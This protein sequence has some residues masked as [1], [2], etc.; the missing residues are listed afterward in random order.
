MNRN[1]DRNGKRGGLSL[2]A[3]PLSYNSLLNK[4]LY[5]QFKIDASRREPSTRPVVN[6]RRVPSWYFPTHYLSSGRHLSRNGLINGQQKKSLP[7]KIWDNICHDIQT[8]PTWPDRTKQYSLATICR[9]KLSSH[10]YSLMVDLVVL[11][12]FSDRLKKV[13]QRTRTKPQES[14]FGKRS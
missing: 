5:K 3:L 14:V 9:N 1:S 12:K 11:T 6:C 10:W 7:R 2:F 4:K 13:T 8:R